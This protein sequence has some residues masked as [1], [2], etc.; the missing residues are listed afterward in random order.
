MVNRN[1]SNLKS[2]IPNLT[3]KI[4]L[5]AFSPH[6]SAYSKLTVLLISAITLLYS[7]TMNV[8]AKTKIIKQPFGQV[9]GQAVDLYT[10]T[11]KNGMEARITNYGG[12][13]VSLRVPDRQG[14]L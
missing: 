3:F 10:L 2:E 8:E 7:S 6:P 11:N 9:D 12:I 4:L 5:S 13:L 14:K 1:I